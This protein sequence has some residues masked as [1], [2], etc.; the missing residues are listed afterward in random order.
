MMIALSHDPCG[1]KLGDPLQG[2]SSACSERLLTL[3]VQTHTIDMAKVHDDMW[4]HLN[5][6]QAG[7]GL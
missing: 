7:L 3:Q 6:C 5:P 2:T 4:H 1:A